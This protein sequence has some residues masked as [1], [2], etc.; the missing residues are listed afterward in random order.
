[1][2]V[3]LDRY[4]DATSQT[5]DVGHNDGCGIAVNRQLHSAAGA[6]STGALERSRRLSRQHRTDQGKQS[7][8]ERARLANLSR[9]PVRKGAQLLRRAVTGRSA[10][11]DFHIYRNTVQ[12]VPDLVTGPPDDLT[13]RLRTLGRFGPGFSHSGP[14]HPVLPPPPPGRD[15]AAACAARPA[16]R[17]DRPF[18]AC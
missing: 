10:A 6:P 8:R 14:H 16:S 18:P 1:M 3:L 9:G 4:S 2:A 15:G 7:I 13:N 17:S 12:S 11:H 5:F